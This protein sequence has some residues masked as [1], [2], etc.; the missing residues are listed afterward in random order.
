[1]NAFCCSFVNP[2]I[3]ESQ[4]LQK[5]GFFKYFDFHSWPFMSIGG[6]ST[7]VFVSVSVPASGVSQGIIVVCMLC[8]SKNGRVE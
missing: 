4:I 8:R 3:N 2:Q 1:M 5:V 7:T 6:K